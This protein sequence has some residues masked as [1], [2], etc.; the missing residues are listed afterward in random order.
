MKKVAFSIM[1]LLLICCASIAEAQPTWT[2][3]Q[4]GNWDD[5]STWTTSGGASGAPSVDID[6]NNIVIITDGDVVT[7]DDDIIMDD[8][9]QLIIENRGELVMGDASNPAPTLTMKSDNNQFI[10][11]NGVYRSRE[12]GSGGNMLIEDG[13]IDWRNSTLYT[14][15]N[16]TFKESTDNTMNSV[17]LRAAQNINFEGANTSV[18]PMILNNVYLIGGVEGTGNVTFKDTWVTV[19]DIRIQVGSTS[20]SAEFF[21]T[22]MNGSIY[23]IRSNEKITVSSMSGTTT[24]EN[25][26]APTLDPD[27]NYFSGPKNNDCTIAIEC[28]TGIIELTIGPCWRMLTSPIEQSYQD[29][30]ALFRTDDTDFGGLWTQG[31]GITGART[32]FGDP[33]VY[34]MNGTG[35]NWTPVTDLTETIPPGTGMLI[36]VFDEDEYQNASSAGFPKTFEFFGTDNSVPVSVDLGTPNGTTD[37]N[38]GYSMLGNP[39]FS[40]VDFDLLTTNGINGTVWIFDRNAG[41]FDVN[42]NNG[43]WISWNG[44]TGD[45][46]D[47]IIAGGQGFVVKNIN[48]TSSP[49]VTFE[50]EDKTTGGT[51]YGKESEKP[52]HIRL[53]VRGPGVYNSA[54]LQFSNDGIHDKL[55]ADDV[56]QFYPFESDYAVLST[57]KEGL[58]MDIGHFPY[59]DE[60]IQIPLVIETTSLDKLTLTLTHMQV[61]SGSSLYLHD[62]VTGNS[63]EITEG[64]EYI[65]T[66]SGSPAKGLADCFS[67][68][69]GFTGLQKEKAA[70]ARFYISGSSSLQQEPVIPNE[71]ALKQN[72]PN[73]F[74]PT[75]QISYQLPQQS[76]VRLEVYDLVGRQVATLVNETMEAGAHTV[77]FNATNLSSG[78]YVYRLNAGS[79]VLSRKLTIIK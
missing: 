51:F 36:S 17:C 76:D 66:P 77:N 71:Y 40:S 32:S 60:E 63:I 72:Y 73:P 10:M 57:L 24:L 31:S 54:W 64:M 19:T 50:E 15:G 22:V 28:S 79:T 20:G 8:N 25:W 3:N 2:S 21:D 56:A 55:M 14:S 12:P 9:G 37:S 47:G 13:T 39:F 53:E 5:A 65:F 42:G 69:I 38:D 70:S 35:D 33:N 27:L 1:T 11:N 68:P 61:H 62:T 16:F 74:N 48:P 59:P 18:D 58:M 78:V 49:N 7:N 75:T 67:T 6:G 43:N 46:T 34:T 4:S 30:F 23:A 29:F 26:C 44:S 41:G 45:I 52:D